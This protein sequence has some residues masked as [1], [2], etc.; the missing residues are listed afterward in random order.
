MISK[1]PATLLASKAIQDWVLGG[2]AADTERRSFGAR[3]AHAS[4]SRQHTA[5]AEPLG[6]VEG[7]REREG[8]VLDTEG[9]DTDPGRV[10]PEA[11]PPVDATSTRGREPQHHQE[12]TPIDKEK[13]KKHSKGLDNS[14][15]IE[16][17]KN[18][19]GKKPDL[20]PFSP[21]F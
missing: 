11:N 15:H 7:Q 2:V 8:R 3:G 12:I 17:L 14:G 4:R 5:C 9:V 6:G 10:R 16:G 21:I 18:E 19:I 20:V 13:T 1:M